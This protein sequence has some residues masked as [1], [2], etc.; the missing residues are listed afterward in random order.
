MPK[1]NSGK[2]KLDTSPTW[3]RGCAT[4]KTP[5]HPVIRRFLKRH[6]SISH[7]NSPSFPKTFLP[8]VAVDTHIT[9]IQCLNRFV[10]KRFCKRLANLSPLHWHDDPDALSGIEDISRVLDRFVRHSS[11]TVTLHSAAF[12]K[13]SMCSNYVGLNDFCAVASRCSLLPYTRSR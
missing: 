9:T 2:H 3:M 6:W 5:C 4:Q 11:H 13:R 10:E 12:K 1:N 8:V 7:I